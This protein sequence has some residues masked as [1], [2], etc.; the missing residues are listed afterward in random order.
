LAGAVGALALAPKSNAAY[1]GWKAALR[2]AED[3]GSLPPPKNI[4]NAPTKM[5][6]DQG[7][8]AG[9]VYDHDSED[10][11]SG[12]N[13]W[14]DG[15]ERLRLY[16]PVERGHERELAKRVAWFEKKRATREE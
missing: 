5:M 2:A 15:M 6:K 8:G 1:A 14:P 16:A 10:G 7:F 4:L 3:T 9:Y 11:F 13:C 12:Q